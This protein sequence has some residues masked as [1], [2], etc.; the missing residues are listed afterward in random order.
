[1]FSPTSIA[2]FLA[3]QHLTALNRAEAAGD[4]KK[5]FFADPGLDLLIKLG[6]A[7][8]QAY[9]THLTEQGLRI[10]EI[11]TDGSRRDA[12]ART[13][14]AIR[15]GAEVI[16]QA[17]F[18]DDQWYGR[19]D[20]LI[21]VDR[22]SNL[23][24]FSYEVVEAKLA[25][26]TKA[27]AI[28]QLCFYSDLLSRIQGVVPDYM[29]VVLGGGAKPEKF[30]VQ[31][32]LAFFRKIKGDFLAVQQTPS[33]TYPEPVEHCRICDWSTVCDAQWRKDDHLSLVANITRNQRQ[34]LVAYGTETVADLARLPVPP[35]PKI[36]GI[37]DQAF[38]NI[39]QQARLQ[40]QGREER[41]NIYELLVPPEPEKGLCSL[42]APSPGDIF[43]DF[44][45][46]QF[47]F[48]GGLEYLFGVLTIASDGQL[49]YDPTWAMNPAEEKRAFQ[50]FMEVV[51]ARR[52]QYPGMHIYHYGSYEATAI[53]RMAGQHSICVDEV[54][55]L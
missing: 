6:Q 52:R 30:F 17:S 7:H 49:V 48:E 20:F 3:C 8:E 55:E 31:R 28:I 53:K 50:K 54:D 33:E 42:P 36:E 34:A 16:Y 51:T 46:D 4:I 29:H 27:R 10:E 32:Y 11:P 39:H 38:A 25:R 40:V 18:L 45:G 13:V 12:A 43:L 1:M 47:T 41:R 23:G 21:R 19:A 14:E 5:P 2:N 44:E 35:E 26:S 15:G 24:S 37:K 9:L 22:P